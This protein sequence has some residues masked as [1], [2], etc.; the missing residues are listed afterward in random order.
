[1][2]LLLVH[3]EAVFLLTYRFE[4]VLKSNKFHYGNV[5]NYPQIGARGSWG[6]SRSMLAR[7][8]VDDAASDNLTLLSQ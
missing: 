3:F 6:M 2:L 4:A 5:E 1:M 7:D 8:G